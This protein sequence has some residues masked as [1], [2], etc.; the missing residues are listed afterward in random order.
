MF[1][2][3][4]SF[5]N[6]DSYDFRVLEEK[7]M[8]ILQLTE[9]YPPFLGGV[10]NVIHEVSKRLVRDGFDVEI[11]CERERGTTS[12]E[13]ID[14]VKV[15]RVFGFRLIKLKYDVGRI[16][17]RMLLSA[18][19][20]D[21]DIIHAHGYGYF[22]TWASMFSNKLTVITTH[23]DPTAKIYPIWDLFRSIPIRRCD[24]VIALTEMEKNHL[25]RRGVKQENI[26]I[27]PNGVKLPPIEA[28]NED[29]SKTIL[30]LARLD[31]AHKGQDILIKA[32]PK[33]LSKLPDVRLYI[34]SGG[35]DEAYLIRLVKKLDID[36]RVEFKGFIS[37]STKALYLK[38]CSLL[39]ISPLTESFPLVYLEAMA[40]GL[41][42]VT[43]RVGGIPEV[44]GD[45]AFLVPPN[46]P[47]VLADALIQVLNDSAL[48]EELRE[49][50]F[51]RVKRFNWDEIVKKYEELY[52]GLL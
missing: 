52:E 6:S 16:A 22:P 9:H 17:P 47:S 35:K 48:A 33:V 50:G 5:P 42:I 34:A 7:K 23:S 30:C 44:V 21:A 24:R 40:Y 28:P 51:R 45:A 20:N 41:P 43:T 10:E 49:E 32:M 46:D 25:I 8:K 39:C 18:I 38:N 11:I 13:V 19:K 4:S 1:P 3:F 26:T 31:T 14:G 37:E 2:I 12:H 36:E 27:I 15:H 29:F